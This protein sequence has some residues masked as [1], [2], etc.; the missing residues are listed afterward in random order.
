MITRRLENKIYPNSDH[1]WNEIQKAAAQIPASAILNMYSSLPDRVQ[2]VC[3]AQGGP[4][5]Y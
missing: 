3:V 4:T 5:R 1:L 2:A